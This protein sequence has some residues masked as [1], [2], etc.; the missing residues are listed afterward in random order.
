MSLII[1][2][3]IYSWSHGLMTGPVIL[4]I[5]TSY[6][7]SVCMFLYVC[8]LLIVIKIVEDKVKSFLGVQTTKQQ[9]KI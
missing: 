5:P 3:M 2:Y 9:V 1:V 4:P 6:C 8:H 7:L